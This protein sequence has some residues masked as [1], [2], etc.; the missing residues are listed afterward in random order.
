MAHAASRA[1]LARDILKGYGMNPKTEKRNLVDIKTGMHRRLHTSAY[2][3]GVN[4][5]LIKAN[6]GS[7]TLITRRNSVFSTLNGLRRG[8]RALS[9]SLPW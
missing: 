9:D 7:L 3:I 2:Y 5:I 8:L 4:A 6:G 1:E